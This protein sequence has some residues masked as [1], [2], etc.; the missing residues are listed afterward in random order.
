MAQRPVEV[1]SLCFYDATVRAKENTITEDEYLQAIAAHCT[2]L[3]HGANQ[4]CNG[5][6][7]EVPE[8]W[9][10]T[11]VQRKWQILFASN[12]VGVE[13]FVSKIKIFIA[14]CVTEDN[15]VHGTPLVYIL[16]NFTIS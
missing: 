11:D 13:F 1:S 12:A 14:Y 15:P 16:R 9:D 6:R 8:H 4:L 5:D 7:S 10:A 3:R 2:S